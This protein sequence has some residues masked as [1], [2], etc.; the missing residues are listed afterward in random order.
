MFWELCRSVY[1]TCAF[2][3]LFLLH[4]SSLSLFNKYCNY[5]AGVPRSLQGPLAGCG[6]SPPFSLTPPPPDAA[7][8]CDSQ[9]NQ[10]HSQYRGKPCPYYTTA[11][12][13]R[14]IVVP[15]WGILARPNSYQASQPLA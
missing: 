4:S 1:L 10:R 12:P 15:P 6:V 13:P 8:E 7:G 3:V 14:R 9:A 2:Q 5:S 11:R